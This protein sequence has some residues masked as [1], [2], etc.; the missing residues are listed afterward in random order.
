MTTYYRIQTAD[1]DPSLL[2]NPEHQISYHWNSIDSEEYTRV[3]VSVCET[4]EDLAAYLAGSGIPYG[5]G[6]WVIIELTGYLSDDDAYDAAYGELLI[7]PTEIV[8]VRPMD[9][10]FF[11]MIAAAYDAAAI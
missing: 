5:D 8:S 7:H 4:L 1:R 2:L 3:G 11:D 9:D 6:E 10:G